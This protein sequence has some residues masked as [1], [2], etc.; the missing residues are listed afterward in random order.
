MSDNPWAKDK[1]I[2]KSRGILLEDAKEFAADDLLL[3][4][5]HRVPVSISK[6]ET[7]MPGY[8]LLNCPASGSKM[9]LF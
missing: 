1:S 2:D 9:W 4:E 8:I 3:C 6:D 7:S 5:T